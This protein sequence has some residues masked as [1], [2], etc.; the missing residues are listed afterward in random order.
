MIKTGRDP[1]ARVTVRK[2]L[3]DGACEFCGASFTRDNPR[4]R[5]DFPSLRGIHSGGRVWEYY[6][7]ADN[8]R[9][10]SVLGRACGIDC[11][12]AYRGE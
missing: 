2:R 1:F 6:V 10:S 7:D 11:L 5:N 3:V 12:R 4:R 8:P 9:E